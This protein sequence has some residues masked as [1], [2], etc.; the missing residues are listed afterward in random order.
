MLIEI[1]DFLTILFILAS[2]LLGAYAWAK[3]GIWSFLL[4]AY[5]S[6][7]LLLIR[8]GLVTAILKTH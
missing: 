8:F 1:I 4:T 2:G 6:A 5:L 7:L 3:L